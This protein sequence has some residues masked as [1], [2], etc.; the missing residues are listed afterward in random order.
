MRDP[1]E[2]ME[3]DEEVRRAVDAWW[4]DP[5]DPTLNTREI[6]HSKHR[7]TLHITPTGR[8]GLIIKGF[9]EKS[10]RPGWLSVAKRLLG[11]APWQREQRG[12][13]SV[14]TQPPLA[15]ALRGSARTPEGEVLLISEFIEGPG[16]G[17]VL[18]RGDVDMASTLTACGQ[19]IARLHRSGMAH[20]DLHPGNLLMAEEGPILIDFQRSS[21]NRPRSRTDDLARLD[22]SLA[23]IEIPESERHALIQLALPDGP[24]HAR[25]HRR[26]LDRSHQL[27]AQHRRTR[28]RQSLHPSPERAPVR[29]GQG[30]AGLRR[31]NFKEDQL[32]A[33][34]HAH[35]QATVGSATSA[36]PSKKVTP[37]QNGDR[38]FRVHEERPHSVRIR[39]KE[40]ILGSPARQ[41]WQSAHDPQRPE[42]GERTLAFSEHR[43][44][45]MP[46]S[47]LWIIETRDPQK[48]AGPGRD[49]ESE[50]M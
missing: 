30:H 47:S 37:V 46:I 5:E 32:E 12:L 15:P 50:T 36:P 44:L 41:A 16:L 23:L 40:S 25:M 49:P 14:Q 11:Q 29:L 31:M 1:L 28:M 34:L 4:R 21:K 7:R 22:F 9:R 2:W 8:P 48:A 38:S 3:G 13:R 10:N 6:T 42:A 19:V 20:G 26:I 33:L 18:H 45:G 24:D 17:E 35:R 27:A 43:I 39:I